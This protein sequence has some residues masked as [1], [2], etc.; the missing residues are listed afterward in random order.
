M[1]SRRTTDFVSTCNPCCLC[2]PL[3]AAMAFSGF[4]GTVPLLHGSQGCSTYIRRTLIGHFREPMDI[5]SSNFHEETAVF[6]GRQNL[7]TALRNV[8][9]QYQPQ[10]I[11]VATTCLAETIGDDVNLFLREIR[12]DA[13]DT[14]MPSL[15]PV[16]TPS[17]QGSHEDGYHAAVCA[18]V[19]HLAATGAAGSHLN[20]F[21]AM[22]SPAD[23]RH[24]REI[25]Q[26]FGIDTT[27]LPDY[28]ERLDGPAWDEFHR[29]PPGG[30]P[31]AAVC[32]AGSAAASIELTAI[33]QHTGAAWLETHCNVPRHSMPIPIGIRL[34][35]QFFSTLEDF[36]R[37]STPTEHLA[38][39][40]RLLDAMADAHKYIFAKRALVFGD[41][42]LV[43]SLS[44]FLSEIGIIPVLCASGGKSRR[45]D[46]AVRRH[47]YELPA[48][49]RVLGDMDFEKI[50]AQLG[51]TPID[52]IIGNSNGYKLARSRQIP[53][54]RVGFPIYD[55]IGAARTLHVGYRGT[56]VLFDRIVNAVVQNAQDA[57][58]VGYTHF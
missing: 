24:L 15:V 2:T 46:E 32:R 6:G 13:A 43:V 37:R 51:N 47:A 33:A 27:L 31:L 39:R 18:I 40:G 17:Y 36:T 7:Q 23:L 29:I 54:V 25:C 12:A 19:E 57:S 35:D 4:E 21:P 10:L 14:A 41:E 28:A 52:L 48:E 49:T 44:A 55:R 50:D 34:T 58:P 56:Q 1:K 42:D 53:L 20:L 5:A 11:G 45:L 30:T 26:S 8:I 38:D 3:G 22:L 16:S 9:R